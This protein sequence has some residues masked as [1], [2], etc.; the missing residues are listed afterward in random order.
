VE[1]KTREGLVVD[2][3]VA[4]EGRDDRGDDLAEHVVMLPG[5]SDP[6][7]AAYFPF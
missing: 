4:I 7:G 3:A 2:S 6:T 1:K 5:Q